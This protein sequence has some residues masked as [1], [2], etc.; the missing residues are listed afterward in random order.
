MLAG[1]KLSLF[2]TILYITKVMQSTLLVFRLHILP[3]ES[4]CVREV[5]IHYFR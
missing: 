3:D 2:H 5:I 1:A 4:G